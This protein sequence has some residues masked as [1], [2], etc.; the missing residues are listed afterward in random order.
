MLQI[1]SIVY[2][3]TL[4][5]IN[6]HAYINK[7]Y[8]EGK[9]LNIGTFV[10]KK[11]FQQ[12]QFSDKLKPLKIGPYKI[13]DR[14]SDVT[15]ELLT[16]DGFTFHTHRNHLVPYNPKEPLIFPFIKEYQTFAE[17]LSDDEITPENNNP[18]SFESFEEIFD[19]DFEKASEPE[20]SIIL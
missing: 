17:L 16:Q 5:K 3:Y 7:T 19:H 1:Y 15:Y 12:V 6:S 14:L 8:N 11:N 4:K 2:N 20:K 10:L 18:T 13:I 9:P